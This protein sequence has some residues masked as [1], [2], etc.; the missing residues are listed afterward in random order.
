MIEPV[1]QRSCASCSREYVGADV[2]CAECRQ[3]WDHA[4]AVAAAV[5]RQEDARK[6]G[7]PRRII[8]LERS[9]A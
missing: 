6:P 4:K 3:V 9:A 8:D 2:L 1:N 5:M 7:R